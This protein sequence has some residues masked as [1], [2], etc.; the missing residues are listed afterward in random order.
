MHN[1]RF[2][3]DAILMNTSQWDTHGGG[4][5]S[6]WEKASAVGLDFLSALSFRIQMC[7]RGRDKKQNMFLLTLF[8]FLQT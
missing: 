3:K 7:S 8:V 2:A 1:Q 6:F 5:S 4:E